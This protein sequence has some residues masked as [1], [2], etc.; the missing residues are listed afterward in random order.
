MLSGDYGD[1]QRACWCSPPQRRCRAHRV[2]A[3]GLAPPGHARLLLR[4]RNLT[5]RAAAAARAGLGVDCDHPA[6]GRSR[7]AVLAVFLSMTTPI[8]FGLGFSSVP[9]VRS[10]GI[11]VA[12]RRVHF[13]RRAGRGS[14][15]TGSPDRAASPSRSAVA[16]HTAPPA[17]SAAVPKRCAAASHHRPRYAQRRASHPPY[18]LAPRVPRTSIQVT[19]RD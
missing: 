8:S 13:P 3:T 19:T 14:P 2:P 11:T 5:P 10:I 6:R 12:R 7:Q 4:A 9:F 15:G 18:G 1:A 17:A 16:C